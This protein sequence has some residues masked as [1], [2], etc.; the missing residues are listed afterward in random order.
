LL[1]VRLW[2]QLSP[3]LPLELRLRVQLLLLRRLRLEWSSSRPR[4]RLPA[5]K[6]L[7]SS[8]RPPLFHRLLKHRQLRKPDPRRM[9]KL[10]LPD[11][12]VRFQLSTPNLLL[13]HRKL[14]CRFHAAW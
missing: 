3:K 9:L 10:P 1:R 4:L 13:R 11:Y 7:L 2:A 12:Q 6:R 8:H 5:K 14:S